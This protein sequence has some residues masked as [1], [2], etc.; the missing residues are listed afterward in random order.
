MKNPSELKDLL[1]E[2]EETSGGYF[3]DFIT[4]RGIQAGIIRLHPGEIDTQEP[5]SADEV[6][7][8]IEG[9]GFINLNYKNHPIKQ[10]TSIFVPAGSEYRFHGN[11]RDLLIFYALGK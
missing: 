1:S 10:G 8:I 4:T 11:T 2:L 7:Y 9:N 5:H 3:V 6:Y